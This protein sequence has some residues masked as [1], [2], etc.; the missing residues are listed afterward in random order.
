M[1]ARIV[2]GS[3][4]MLAGAA[5]AGI[6]LAQGTW[7]QLTLSDLAGCKTVIAQAHQKQFAYIEA[8]LPDY[9]SPAGKWSNA[10]SCKNQRDW[11]AETKAQDD[12]AWYFKGNGHCEGSDYPCFG[13]Q[14]FNDVRSGEDAVYWS[15]RFEE[16]AAEGVTITPDMTFDQAA[17]KSD[18]CLAGLWV[19][20]FKAAGGAPVKPTAATVT[21]APP[22][23]TPTT[24]ASFQS[25]LASSN[26]DQL[27]ALTNELLTTGQIDLAKLARN[28][29]LS[30]YPDSPLV[31]VV[32]QLIANASKPGALPSAIS[33]ATPPVSAQ[34]IHINNLPQLT[35]AFAGFGVT[36]NP[37]AGSTVA[38]RES[39][40]LYTAYLSDCRNDGQCW[41]LQLQAGYALSPAPTSDRIQQWNINKL[42]GRAYL[43]GGRATFDMVL[44]IPKEG[45]DADTL[46]DFVTL[47]KDASSAFY[48]MMVAQ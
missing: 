46:A 11:L 16:M 12:L 6:A 15:G 17:Y 19:K 39:N 37:V 29:L 4:C 14:L 18:N 41:A 34:Q 26:A 10:E 48:N 2:A 36:L 9:C 8:G 44:R 28:A 21:P 31:P 40:N 5:A 35:A 42:Y 3:G 45:I 24:D 47:Y 32:V 25:Q 13:P 33:S 27:L 30:R 20:K 23:P 7:P 38:A 22:P 1:I 43:S